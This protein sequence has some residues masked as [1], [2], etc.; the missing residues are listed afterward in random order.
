MLCP[1]SA[2]LSV[3]N[4]PVRATVSASHLMQVWGCLS[5]KMVHATTLW[6]VQACS[7]CLTFLQ[8][9]G[10]FCSARDAATLQE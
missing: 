4:R 5:S 7:G 10:C 1:H 6:I 9:L 3:S 2:G 8:D